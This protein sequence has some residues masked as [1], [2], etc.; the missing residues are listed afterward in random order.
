M[1]LLGRRSSPTWSGRAA[2]S[3]RGEVA[4]MA[5]WPGD[6]SGAE[7]G[8]FR[9][10]APPGATAVGPARA[11]VRDGRV[12]TPR[13]TQNPET[14]TLGIPNPNA[15][16]S[17]PK[18]S[19]C[20]TSQTQAHAK[21]G[22]PAP[23][24]FQSVALEAVLKMGDVNAKD[25][26]NMA[27]AY[28]TLKV[29]APALFEAMAKHAPKKMC[30]FKPQE[31]AHTAWAFSE[32]GCAAP[33]LFGAIADRARQKISAFNPRYLALIVSAF[34]K[35]NVQAP[36]LFEAVAFEAQTPKMVRFSPKELCA[37]LKAFSTLKI[38]APLFFERAANEAVQKLPEYAPND[39]ADA[40]EA[41]AAMGDAGVSTTAFV[42]VVAKLPLDFIVALD[43]HRTLAIVCAFA[44]L[45]LP[46][47]WLDAAAPKMRELLQKDA[48]VRIRVAAGET[49]AAARVAAATASETAT[50]DFDDA[51]LAKLYEA[52]GLLQLD[53]PDS[54]VTRLLGGKCGAL[55]AAHLRE[56]LR[57]K[58]S[59]N[60]LPQ[61]RLDAIST[62][63]KRIGWAH[64]AVYVTAE[65]VCVDFAQP[66]AG[67]AI[68]VDAADDYVLAVGGGRA[69][70]VKGFTAAERRGGGAGPAS[71]AAWVAGGAIAG[72]RVGRG[73]VERRRG[74]PVRL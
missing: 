74:A 7:T 8:A 47:T 41:F 21:C 12:P 16:N 51:E 34:A 2:A 22:Y 39:V 44:T 58:G 69:G 36:M 28:V 54:A 48:P 65:G 52:Y 5:E 29:E 62:A 30:T 43:A 4:V 63:L 66:A 73:R 3:G 20:Q 11:A 56:A 60:G 33:A 27:W 9:G 23:A 46:P 45:G 32:A 72:S 25:V 1:P 67:V 40:V 57:L 71:G 53:A 42:K 49:A 68:I 70:A 61:V 6:E 59:E 31:L 19:E 55:R 10:D 38:A 18:R 15:R 35:A 37:T 17:T 26:T 14:Q 64:E 24:L 13:K 50:R